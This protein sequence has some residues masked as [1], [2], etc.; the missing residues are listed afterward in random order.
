MKGVR[1]LVLGSFTR[2][3]GS[4]GGGRALGTTTCEQFLD[5]SSTLPASGSVAST[6]TTSASAAST[7][8]TLPTSASVALTLLA[9]TFCYLDMLS[10]SCSVRQ[11]QI[12]IVNL[13][14]HISITVSTSSTL[15]SEANPL[16]NSLH[17]KPIISANFGIP[18]LVNRS[19]T[20]NQAL[21]HLPQMTNRL[22]I[23]WINCTDNLSSNNFA[24]CPK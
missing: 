8:L 9:C 20:L 12:I 13:Y 14:I 23:S 18:N 6:S 7:A 24:T 22:T 19:F 1:V 5:N 10:V 4:W 15:L 2:R 16:G 17:L 21:K 3:D 11:W